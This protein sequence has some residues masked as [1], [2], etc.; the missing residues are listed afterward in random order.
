[1]TGC[2]YLA[3]TRV[4]LSLYLCPCAHLSQHLLMCPVVAAV[5]AVQMSQK[6]SLCN[7]SQH[8]SL[9]P[10]VATCV[11][12]TSCRNICCCAQVSLQLSLCPAVATVLAVP[13]CRY[14]YPCAPLPLHLYLCPAVAIVVAASSSRH[15]LET[16]YVETSTVY[17]NESNVG[18]NIAVRYFGYVS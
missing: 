10:A 7:L 11:P 18:L 8:V 17:V 16:H 13:S 15:N 1:M 12:V 14:I 6:L 9:C 5:V 3:Q 4:R 2:N